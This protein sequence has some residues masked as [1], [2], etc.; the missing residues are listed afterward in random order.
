M[1][2]FGLQFAVGASR[3]A[4]RDNA[5]FTNL[6]CAAWMPR[7][8]KPANRPERGARRSIDRREYDF[9]MKHWRLKNPP[10]GPQLIMAAV[11]LGILLSGVT[12]TTFLLFVGKIYAAVLAALICAGVYIRF[13]RGRLRRKPIG[14][15]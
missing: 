11:Y 5:T 1:P 2:F 3:D 7:S 4:G 13:K 8:R 15:T 14:K 10:E 12:A 9:D 6:C